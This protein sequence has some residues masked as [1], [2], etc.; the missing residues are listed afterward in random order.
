MVQHN[1]H[2]KNIYKMKE[3]K[4]EYYIWVGLYLGVAF[5]AAFDKIGLGICRGLVFGVAM[6]NKH[7]NN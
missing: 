1:M 2:Q 7:T 6:Q 3:S 4:K 5:G